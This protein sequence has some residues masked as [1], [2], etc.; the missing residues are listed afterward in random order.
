[1]LS[2]QHF[3][4]EPRGKE[5]LGRSPGRLIKPTRAGSLGKFVRE[6]GAFQPQTSLFKGGRRRKGKSIRKMDAQREGDL[7]TL[8]RSRERGEGRRLKGGKE[9]AENASARRQPAKGRGRAEAEMSTSARRQPAHGVE[10]SGSA[11]LNG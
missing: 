5:A 1:M 8:A 6:P 10:E 2:Q 9:A 11:S 3:S 4:V 7:A